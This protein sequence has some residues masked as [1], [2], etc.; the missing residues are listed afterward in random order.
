MR[1]DSEAIGRA[2]ARCLS[3]RREIQA[4][5]IFGSVATCRT[6]PDSDVDVAV[7]TARR[8]R[9]A[10]TLKYRLALMADPGS[11]PGRPDVEVVLLNEAPPLL[12]HR[13]L[14]QGALVFER[15]RS[16]RVK[17]QV[18]TVNRYLDVI[19]M[20]ETHIEYLKKRVRE[21]R[22][23]IPTKTD[24]VESRKSSKWK[25]SRTANAEPNM[26]TNGEARTKKCERRR[27]TC[28]TLALPSTPQ[29]APASR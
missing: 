19:P 29:P 22:R 8:A 7:L 9:R 5:Y 14:S 25:S 18:D 26:N 4:V 15:S 6:R 13:I 20:F 16:A 10:D 3:K 27:S 24:Q 23:I 12:A 28:V 2:V 17:F 21:G 1:T 11:A